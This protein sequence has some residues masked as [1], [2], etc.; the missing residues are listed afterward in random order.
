MSSAY[1]TW[2]RK[3]T[4]FEIEGCTISRTD[5]KGG[6]AIFIE[7]IISYE[8]T[9]NIPHKIEGISIKIRTIEQEINITTIYLPPAEHIDFGIIKPI[10]ATKNRFICVDEDA[11]NTPWGAAKNDNQ[12]KQLGEAVDELD[13]TVVN[14]GRGTRLNTA[15]LYTSILMSPLPAPTSH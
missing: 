10:L 3:D 13:L 6:G 11:K 4:K 15:G 8:K 2:L 1:R 9:L 5:R 12:G 7:G 14:T